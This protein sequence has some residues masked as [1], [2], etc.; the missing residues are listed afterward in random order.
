MIKYLETINLVKKKL[1]IKLRI[2]FL[3][4]KMC[5]FQP[6]KSPLLQDLLGMVW[7]TFA[8]LSSRLSSLFCTW[9]HVHSNWSL[10]VFNFRVN[11]EK[12]QQNNNNNNNRLFQEN[13][14]NKVRLYSTTSSQFPTH[15][16]HVIQL[17]FFCH[18]VLSELLSP[19]VSS[20]QSTN[21]STN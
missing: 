20:C 8:K 5:F 21:L 9:Q 2:F 3:Q 16:I 10:H 17:I 7:N 4:C 13:L 19:L 18:W 14:F 11:G 15:S 6:K 1:R 12:K